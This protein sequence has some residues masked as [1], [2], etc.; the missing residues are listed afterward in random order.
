[1]R[2][3]ELTSVNKGSFNL[4]EG[5]IPV[6]LTM[7]LEQVIRDG[8]V[9]NSVQNYVLGALIEMF[10]NGGPHRWPRDLNAY[11]MTTSSEL[12]EQVKQITAEDAVA[13]SQWLLVELYSTTAYEN[14]P[15]ASPQSDV[16]GWMRYV[17][18]RQ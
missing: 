10:K 15:Y 16:V 17:L 5:E 18:K 8:K 14:N 2:L 6:H 9:T 13:I 3:N 7:T 11:S 12:I 4:A 1:M